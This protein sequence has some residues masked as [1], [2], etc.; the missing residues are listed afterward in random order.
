MKS[1]NLF[2]VLFSFAFLSQIS[3]QDSLKVIQFSG[4]VQDESGRE[5]IYTN[6]AVKGTSRGTVSDID[7]FFSLPVREKEVVQFSRIG[8]GLI[9]FEVPVGLPQNYYSENIVMEKDTL[10]L[11]EALIYPW[12]DKDFFRN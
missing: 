11:P 5:L 8:Y 1:L 10:F 3:G 9:E 6:I 7:G 2:L 4:I 12:P